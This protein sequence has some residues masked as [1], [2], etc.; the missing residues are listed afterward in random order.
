MTNG[1][2]K[3]DWFSK[4]IENLTPE[5]A[6]DTEKGTDAGKKINLKDL[7]EENNPVVKWYFSQNEAMIK[8]VVDNIC[9]Q[10][11]LPCSLNLHI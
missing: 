4:E 11:E 1:G 8:Y 5:N 9:K 6:S 2:T 3:P 10:L 7:Y